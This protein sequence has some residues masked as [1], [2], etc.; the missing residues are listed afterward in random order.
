MSRCFD[1]PFMIVRRML[2]SY[3]ALQDDCLLVYCAVAWQT[4]VLMR[5]R[6]VTVSSLLDFDRLVINR[7]VCTK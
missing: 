2:S 5:M 4:R 6:A 3:L 1:L 7:I